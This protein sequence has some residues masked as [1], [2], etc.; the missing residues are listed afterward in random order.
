ML[1]EKHMNILAFAPLYNSENKKDAT[2]AFQ[3]EAELFLK[4]HSSDLTNP[5][6]IDNKQSKKKM[7]SDV[8]SNIDKYQP[9]MLAFFCHGWK[10]GIQFGFN[11]KNLVEIVKVFP[12]NNIAPIVCIY[13][14]L[15]A[16]GDG[17]GGDGGFADTL[18]DT[19]CQNG[20]RHVQVDAHV[21]AGHATRNPFVRRFEGKGSPVGGVGGYYLVQ[22]KSKLWKAWQKGLTGSLRFRFPFMSVETIHTELGE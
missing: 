4:F 10:T 1:K 20:F 22:P 17:P 9:E 14:C 11:L 21:T 6:L 19:F 15:T 13:G 3:P 12:T 8:V 16:D 5:I 18:R 2:G 7:M